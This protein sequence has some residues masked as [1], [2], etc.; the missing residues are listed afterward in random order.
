ML[1]KPKPDEETNTVEEAP[2]S[3]DDREAEIARR[4]ALLTGPDEPEAVTAPTKTEPEEQV[5]ASDPVAPP[6][7]VPVPVEVP[8]SVPAPVQPMKPA[9]AAAKPNNKNALLVSILNVFFAFC[10]MFGVCNNGSGK[11]LN[12]A[13]STCPKIHN[14]ISII[15]V[16]LLFVH[17]HSFLTFSQM[18]NLNRRQESWQLRKGPRMLS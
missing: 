9:A 17:I 6:A 5:I 14:P 2:V 3:T 11:S 1:S 18:Q 13:Y 15:K 16:V 12:N 4:L 10:G 8:K 7:P